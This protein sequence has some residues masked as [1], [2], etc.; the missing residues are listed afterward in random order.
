[1]QSTASPLTLGRFAAGDTLAWSRVSLVST[2]LPGNPIVFDIT[3]DN[4]PEFFKFGNWSLGEMENA[5]LAN[6]LDLSAIYD[7]S[8]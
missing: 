1:M 6:N 8:T 2:K 4:T 5:L 3:K 7:N